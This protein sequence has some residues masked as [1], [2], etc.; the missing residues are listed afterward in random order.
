MELAVLRIFMHL[1]YPKYQHSYKNIIKICQFSM[2]YYPMIGGGE[3]VIH[4]LSQSLSRAGHEVAVLAPGE[5]TQ[6]LLYRFD[7]LSLPDQ[8]DEFE[9]L[10]FKNL[11]AEKKRFDFDVLQAHF[12]WPA[13]YAAAL[14]GKRNGIPTVITC[15]GIDLN[16][17][18]Q[19]GY[20][21]RLQDDLDRKI[22][23][24]IKEAAGVVCVSRYLGGKAIEAGCSE[25]KL[26]I[27]PNGV[28][29]DEFS[30]PGLK[31][32]TE[33]YVLFLGNLRRVKG[34]DLLLSAF[35][36]VARELGDTKLYLVGDGEEKK[37]LVGNALKYSSLS[38]RIRF[39]SQTTGR[40]KALLFANCLFF[41]C[42]SRME[43][44]PLVN[45]EAMAASKPVIAFDVG[46]VGELIVDGKN[47]FLIRPYDI[48]TFSRMIKKLIVDH[49][50]REI[51]GQNSWKSAQNYSWKSVA[52]QYTD[53]YYS[54]LGCPI[55]QAT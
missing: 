22:K 18:R 45:L 40:E 11:D 10:L 47:G 26:H 8:Y 1:Y 29:L 27:I 44:F 36:R 35:G 28:A 17:D 3:V 48:D 21:I 30:Q 25:D 4:N 33:P 37:S 34:V 52:A 6:D 23:R 14:W 49:E 32:Q 43:A 55:Y 39:L 16:M 15:H 41:V 53:L 24:A 46:G 7:P 13:G 31:L 19:I 54:L 9:D 42:P 50:L 51:M 38:G 12:V 20:G 5:K 2:Q